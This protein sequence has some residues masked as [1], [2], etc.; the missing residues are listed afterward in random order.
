MLRTQDWTSS[1]LAG[2][3]WSSTWDVHYT[4]YKTNVRSVFE[5]G[6]EALI[7]IL[8]TNSKKLG[9]FPKSYPETC[10]RWYKTYRNCCCGA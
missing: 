2:L 8:E 4:A 6:N 1:G 5:Y 9:I 10:C 3:T 7:T